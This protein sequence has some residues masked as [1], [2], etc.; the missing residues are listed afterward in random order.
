MKKFLNFINIPGHI[1][2]YRKRKIIAKYTGDKNEGE[3]VKFIINLIIIIGYFTVMTSINFIY[4]SKNVFIITAVFSLL[5]FIIIF[6][7]QK[8]KI[9]AFGIDNTALSKLILKDDD[10]KF[11]KSWEMN[12]KTSLLI[13]KKTKNNEIDID[14]SDTVYASLVSREHAV[15]N[16][17][18]KQWYFEDIGSSNGSGIKRKSDGKKF[19]VEEG[20]AYRVYNGDT[21]YIANTQIMVK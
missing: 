3:G 19:K 15:L 18:G 14:L 12:G 5:L 2:K 1:I 10:G 11:I 8:K 20:K 9:W 6:V 13:G 7:L 21:I 17:T 16:Y 4:R